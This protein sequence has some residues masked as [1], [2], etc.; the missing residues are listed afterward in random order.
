[1]SEF[2]VNDKS[3]LEPYRADPARYAGMDYHR[4]G[5]TGLKLPALSL[6][7]W[8]NFGFVDRLANS[9]DILRA[10]FDLGIVHWDLANNYGPPYGSAEQNFGTLFKADFAAHRDELIIA[11]K[12]GYDMW[13]GPYGR[14][15]SR[16]YLVASLDQSLARMGLDYVDIFYHHCPDPETPVEESLGAVRDI[17]RQGKSLYAGV[18][19]YGPELTR[20]A[21][22]FFAAEGTPFVLH[23]AKFSLLVRKPEEGLLDVLE[24]GGVGCIAFSPLAQGLLTNRY[25]D[26]VPA[27]SRAARPYTYLGTEAV[28]E[29]QRRLAALNGI[30]A[31]RGQSLAQMA[32]AWLLTRKAVCSVLA[33]ASSAAQLRDNVGALAAPAF[34]AGTLDAIDAALSG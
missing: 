33:G 19:N 28:T 11:T 10:A 12:A 14:G 17:V 13:P 34:D 24:T 18:S 3:G 5:R 15:G 23:Q 32:L 2:P 8:H 21:I 9:R 7:L 27:D 30:A 20:R 4:A 26:G 1:M 31:E 22:E 25:L 6:G 16:K 29:Q